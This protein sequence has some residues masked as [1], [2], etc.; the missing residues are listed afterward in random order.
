MRNPLR[1]YYL[2]GMLNLGSSSVAQ[3]QY[4]RDEDR[5][6]LSIEFGLATQ[7]GR[8]VRPHRLQPWLVVR[9]ERGLSCL[10]PLAVTVRPAA[11]S[12]EFTIAGIDPK[13]QLCPSAVGP[14][15]GGEVLDSRSG[16]QNLTVR[17]RSRVDTLRAFISDTLVRLVHQGGSLTTIPAGSLHL[18][19]PHTVALYCSLPWADST[20]VL[21]Q[22]WVCDDFADSLVRALHM[23]EVV[24]PTGPGEWFRAGGDQEWKSP[25][26]FRYRRDED[27]VALYYVM[28]RFSETVMAREAPSALISVKNALGEEL[29]SWRFANGQF[30]AAPPEL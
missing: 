11:Q 30:A 2:A 5:F 10:L 1:V 6:V 13:A 27:L 4:L 24:L 20:V 22:T 14:A 25:R 15:T 29:Q 9:T 16:W 17:W 3:A 23:H 12:T 19:P 28:R 8:P 26:F 21:S 7:N 18:A